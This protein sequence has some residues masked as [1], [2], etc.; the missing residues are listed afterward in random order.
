[1]VSKA[2][3]LC[4]MAPNTSGWREEAPSVRPRRPGLPP[5]RERH[6][7]V[8][9]R[10]PWAQPP[11][12]LLPQDGTRGGRGPCSGPPL[13][14]LTFW[15]DGVD[16]AIPMPDPGRT[17][18]TLYWKSQRRARHPRPLPGQG[19]PPRTQGFLL[20]GAPHSKTPLG[21]SLGR[22]SLKRP[23]TDCDRDTR[24]LSTTLQPLKNASALPAMRRI[25]CHSSSFLASS[26]LL[27]SHTFSIPLI[28]TILEMP[29]P[30]GSLP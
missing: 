8:P 13:G 5:T 11:G 1:M 9:G 28:Q 3:S 27:P 12:R 2:S 16:T 24:A 19:H 10:L 7:S 20:H 14:A 30:A 6:P 21:A 23:R 17:E 22:R 18:R 26:S 25:G 15:V 4:T 29:P